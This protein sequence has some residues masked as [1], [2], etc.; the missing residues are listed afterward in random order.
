[1]KGFEHTYKIN[2][3]SE[4][5]NIRTGKKVHV[6][7]GKVHLWKDGKRHV[8]NYK[9]LLKTKPEQPFSAFKDGEKTHSF[10]TLKEVEQHGFNIKSVKKVLKGESKTHNKHAF[11]YD[12]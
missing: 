5:F 1:M 9:D 8:K 3:K 12:G 4:I 6:I 11:A 10:K 7:D 2:N